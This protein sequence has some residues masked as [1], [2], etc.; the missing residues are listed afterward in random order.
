MAKNAPSQQSQETEADSARRWLTI[1]L[2]LV[3][4]LVGFEALAVAT[5]M[6]AVQDSL[7]QLELYG[8]VFSAFLTTSILGVVVAGEQCDQYGLARQIG[9]AHV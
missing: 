3:V 8:W 2:V 4:T 1:G 5:T 6:P 7:G 9:R